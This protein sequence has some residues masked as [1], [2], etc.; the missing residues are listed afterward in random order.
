MNPLD[1]AYQVLRQGSEV[2]FIFQTGL[3]EGNLSFDPVRPVILSR[4]KQHF[5]P[6]FVKR[7]N[8]LRLEMFQEG[9]DGG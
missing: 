7:I 2:I 5:T 3:T 9:Y 1:A 8:S 4:K 6:Q